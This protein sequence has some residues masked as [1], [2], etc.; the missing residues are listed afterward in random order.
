MASIIS[1]SSDSR[2]REMVASSEFVEHAEV[3]GNLY[4]TS[5][6]QLDRMLGTG[7]DL[8]LEIDWQGARIVRESFPSNVSIFV[9]PPSEAVLRERLVLRG[10]DPNV[11]ERRMRAALGEMSH[12]AEYD[13]LLVNDDFE[14]ALQE[15]CGAS[16]SQRD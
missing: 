1:S 4:G 8:V 6:Q 2:F 5:K 16:S 11:I 3:F 14:T 15:L 13:Y 9:L 7:T 12:Y 10:D